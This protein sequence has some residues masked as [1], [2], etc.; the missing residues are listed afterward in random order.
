MFLTLSREKSKMDYLF[1]LIRIFF[2]F[3]SNNIGTKIP[4]HIDITHY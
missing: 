3:Q 4:K 1:R 2:A